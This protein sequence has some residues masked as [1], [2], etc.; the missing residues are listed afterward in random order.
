MLYLVPNMC[1]LAKCEIATVP[2]YKVSQRPFPF[3]ALLDV[4][5]CSYSERGW[6]G[7]CCCYEEDNSV[8]SASSSDDLN[9]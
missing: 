1:G 6:D 2:N 4:F 3:L 7:N 8:A 9:V 5:K